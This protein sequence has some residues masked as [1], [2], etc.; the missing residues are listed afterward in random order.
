MRGRSPTT[1]AIAFRTSAVAIAKVDPENRV[2]L[3]RAII[4]AVPWLKAAQGRPIE[5]VAIP[6]GVAV[7]LVEAA[8]VKA[9]RASFDAALSAALTE[10]VAAQDSWVDA[11]RLLASAWPVT[12]TFPSKKQIRFHLP[13][14]LRT[15]GQLPE[16][17]GVIAA[18]AMGTLLELWSA[19]DWFAY[20]RGLA[21]R[22]DDLIADAVS[23]LVP[24]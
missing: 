17:G 9:D 2:V 16:S 5:C 18:F 8:G 3:P 22:R 23:Q 10:T 12:V 15:V 6:G 20:V 7:Q 11:A 19:S 4:E 1:P 13:L 24:E 14:E 21:A